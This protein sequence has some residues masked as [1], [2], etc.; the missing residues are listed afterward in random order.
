MSHDDAVAQFVQ[1]LSCP[2]TI[3]FHLALDDAPMRIFSGDWVVQVLDRLG[4]GPDDCIESR[5]VSR[6]I[7]DA[8]RMYEDAATGDRPADSAEEWIR[9]N[10]PTLANKLTTAG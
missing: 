5:M 6:R 10:C 4:M 1:G 3:T 7:R 8:S 9:L 2:A